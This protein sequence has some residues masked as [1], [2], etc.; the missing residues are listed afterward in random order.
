MPLRTAASSSY[1]AV[2]RLLRLPAAEPPEPL[3]GPLR[4]ELLGTDDLA[5]RARAAARAQ[6]VAAPGR[7]GRATPLLARLA[8]T[9]RILDGAHAR[10]S[11]AADEGA[12]VGP[13]GDWL[14]D[15]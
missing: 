7:E 10:L 3:S 6:R 8:A 14:L 13:A 4:G 9:R 12:D 11:A 15:N 1:R 2:S 5:G